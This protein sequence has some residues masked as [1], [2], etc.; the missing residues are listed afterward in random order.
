MKVMKAKVTKR[1]LVIPKEMLGG[2][3]EVEIRKEDSQI[4]VSPLIKDDPIL[5]LGRHPVDC[6]LPDGSEHHDTYLYGSES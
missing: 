5:N 2:I 4:V 1:G 3:E 6:G